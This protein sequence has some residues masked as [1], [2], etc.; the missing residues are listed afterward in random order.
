M[1]ITITRKPNDK[2]TPGTISVDGKT[3]CLSLEPKTPRS[4]AERI[5]GKCCVPLGKYKVKPRFEG[6]VYG[7]MSKKVPEVKGKGIPHIVNIDGVEYPFWCNN[8]EKS[9]PYGIDESRFVLFHI[10]NSIADTRGCCLTGMVKES[11]STISQS[12][13]AFQKLY[14]IIE[15]SMTAGDLFVEYVEEV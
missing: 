4:D 3:V 15:P 6:D 11:E 10:G 7:W 2:A 1:L 9:N 8:A 14:S 13:V 12:T 5:A